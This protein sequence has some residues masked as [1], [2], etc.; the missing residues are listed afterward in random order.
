M[1][2]HPLIEFSFLKLWATLVSFL[3]IK[4]TVIYPQR[5]SSSLSSLGRLPVEPINIL[6]HS[7]GLWAVNNRRRWLRTWS[8][9]SPPHRVVSSIGIELRWHRDTHHL[10]LRLRLRHSQ[11]RHGLA[12][13]DSDI[14]PRYGCPLLTSVTPYLSNLSHIYRR[15]IYLKF[16]VNQ[17][18][19]SWFKVKVFNDQDLE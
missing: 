15:H 7:L 19:L 16:I 13:I 5:P 6:S 14:R 12:P 3:S 9:V 2:F 11:P 17:E 18:E 4:P 8:P 10:L 1:H